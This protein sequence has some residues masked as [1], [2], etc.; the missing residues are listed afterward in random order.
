MQIPPAVWSAS[1]EGKMGFGGDV[2][3]SVSMV[4]VVEVVVGGGGGGGCSCGG[5]GGG[6]AQ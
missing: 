1:I 6:G 2:G 3:C 5:G 4:V